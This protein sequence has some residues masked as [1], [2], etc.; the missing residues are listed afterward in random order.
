MGRA[1]Q[2]HI[3]AGAEV[4]VL[5]LGELKRQF[6]DEGGDVGVRDHL[7][8][9]L[10][11]AEHILGDVN[12]HVLFDRRL[13]RQAPAFIGFATGEVGRLGR[14]H[15]ATSLVDNALALGAGA[16]TATGGRQE[17]VVGRQGLQQLAARGNL[18]FL[19]VVDEDGH[20]TGSDQAGPGSQDDR[21]QRQ[22][23]RREHHDT[24]NDRFHKTAFR[25]QVNSAEGHEAQRHES[26]DY[27]SNPEALQALWNI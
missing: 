22:H 7:A 14:Q 17:D 16:A 23:H 20:V 12:F 5:A 1:L 25:L 26:H 24:K 27:E 19:F 8:L 4:H 6:L 10:L 9:P 11:H 3:A 13:A 2:L 15:G 21:H 18:D